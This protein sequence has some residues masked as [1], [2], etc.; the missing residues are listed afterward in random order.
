[1]PSGKTVTFSGAAEV[2]VNG[3]INLSG[4][5]NTYGNLPSNLKLY[6]TAGAGVDIGTNASSPIYAEIYAPNSPFNLNARTFYG[7]LIST[8]ISVNSN[9]NMYIDA[10]S[11]T[12]GFGGASASSSTPSISIVRPTTIN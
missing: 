12:G 7:S 3:S 11:T 2:Y 9:F 6:N 8:G 4:A 1:V 5:V 10:R